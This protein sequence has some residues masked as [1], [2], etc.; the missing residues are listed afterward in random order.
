MNVYSLMKIGKDQ[1]PRLENLRLTMHRY[2][3][4]TTCIV[5]LQDPDGALYEKIAVETPV[6]IEMGY[7]LGLSFQWGGTIRTKEKDADRLRLYCV[8]L[9]QVLETEV[10]QVWLNEQPGKIIQ[11]MVE[12]TG[13]G[14]GRLQTTGL[15]IPRFVVHNKPIWEAERLLQKT[16]DTYGV[17]TT[18]LALWIGADHLVQWGTHDE[19]GQ[20]EIVSGE[21]MIAYCQNEVTALLTPNLRASQRVH[22][23]APGVDKVYRAVRVVHEIGKKSRTFVQVEETDG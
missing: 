22:V 14:V 7:R 18:K 1:Y 2:A 15:T 23:V 6:D 20:I 5:D 8:G 3:P 19:S 13:F 17:D 21:N 4:L 11:Q 16:M 12:N 10:K 9:E